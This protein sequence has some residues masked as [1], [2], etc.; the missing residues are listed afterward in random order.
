MRLA[1]ITTRKHMRIILGAV[2][3][4]ICLSPLHV[5]AQEV[6]T[7]TV[8]NETTGEVIGGA[9]IR[10][11]GT[12]RGTY[13]NG[14]G[15]FRLPLTKDAKILH[16]RSIGYEERR[17][18]LGQEESIQIKLKPSSLGFSA[19]E[20]MGEITPEEVIKRTIARVEENNNRIKS[21]VSTL[22]SK[23]RVRIDGQ[24]PGQ[25]G[26]D[27]SIS[28][29]FSKV[30]DQRSPE[31]R[32]RVHI[33]QRRQ[34]R[35]IAAGQ[36]FTVFD[37]F[38][39]F[40][41]PE[42]RLL[43][44]RLVTPLA[45]DALDFYTYTILGK[46][47]L[48][49]L[50]VY[51]ISFE[52]SSRLFPGFEGML[53]IVDGTYQVI[54]A[55]F[56]PTEETSFPFLTGLTYMQRFE[57]F[58]DSL[59]VPMYQ[60]VSA[61]GKVS[62]LIGVV[63]VDGLFKAETYVT[64]VDVNSVI[65]DS[66]FTVPD[67]APRRSTASTSGGVTVR[68]RGGDRITTVADDA[69]SSKPEFWDKYAFAEQSDEER[70]AYHR[71]DSIAKASPRPERDEQRLSVGMLNIGPV[72]INLNPV[73]DRTSITGWM[74]GGEIEL[75]FDRFALTSSGT[76]GERWTKAG[77]VALSVGII[78]ERGLHFTASGSVFSS[79][80]T[81]QTPRPIFGRVNFLNLANI[82]Y[83][84]NHDYYRRD[85]FDI[86]LSLRV[87]DVTAE[88]T[89]GEARHMNGDIIDAPSRQ[90]I[91]AVA[92]NYRTVQATIGLFQPTFL[93]QMFGRVSP[94]SGSITSILGEE[95][96]SGEQFLTV[97]AAASATLNTFSTGYSP[98]QI[99]LDLEG[100]ISLFDSLPR[101][102]Q[103][104]LLQRYPVFG[105][106]S[107]VATVPINAY[108]G[109]SFI[110]AHVEHN[111]TDLWWRAIG[112]PGISH[113]RG[114]DLIGIV[115]VSRAWQNSA[116]VVPGQIWDA[117]GDWYMEAGFAL[118]RIP[119][120]VSDLFFLRFDA[121]WPIGGFSQRGSFGWSIT[122]SSPLL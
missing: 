63:E 120:F 21:I 76:I 74:F 85:G 48:G 112:I 113:G 29:T 88:V 71:Q 65:D 9:S 111:F 12:T 58:N 66:V 119:T 2:V 100:G 122:L 81:I 35:N 83:A 43:N 5:S 96:I 23:M 102:Y 47:Q 4:L 3:A 15:T 34:T 87:D 8:V 44:T 108:G 73:I 51:E 7:G 22:Y 93:Q 19:V 28:E 72:G 14:R 97:T 116:P 57:R 69:D 6:I 105:V 86:G 56:A 95:T 98:M 39:D 70:E 62:V 55:R 91:T 101:Q 52:P 99:K 32:K 16:V 31:S 38:F 13:T 42:L 53:T 82:L 90:S 89:I 92:G 64:D 114:L 27:E 110:H 104:S 20:V 50:L 37:Q 84:Y 107:N 25:N 61:R 40:T 54:E 115:D 78:D 30:Y 60:E 1:E 18:T 77:S 45:H 67:T 79:L 49:D 59:W 68:I 26:P 103:F 36:N 109:T 117:T 11:E 10:I 33:L 106:T 80:A 94:V 24:I 121:L 41:T 46:R 118:A 17:V 75:L